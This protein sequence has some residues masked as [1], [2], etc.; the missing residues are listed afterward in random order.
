M[1]GDASWLLTQTNWP[2]SVEGSASIDDHVAVDLHRRLDRVRI[3]AGVAF[4]SARLRMVQIVELYPATSLR[5]LPS[6]ISSIR[7]SILRWSVRRRVGCNGQ[8]DRIGPDKAGVPGRACVERDIADD[9]VAQ[10]IRSGDQ[11]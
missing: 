9:A 7:R 2:T 6:S 8:Q 1:E 5:R 3:H 10:L 11:Q 4:R